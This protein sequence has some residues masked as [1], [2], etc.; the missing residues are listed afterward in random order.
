M[1]ADDSIGMGSFLIT[2]AMKNE[3]DSLNIELKFNGENVGVCT[4]MVIFT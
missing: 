2:E 3:D 4:L 1:S